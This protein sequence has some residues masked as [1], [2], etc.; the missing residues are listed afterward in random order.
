VF[1]GGLSCSRTL[2]ARH[3]RWLKLSDNCVF[4]KPGGPDSIRIF[5]NHSRAAGKPHAHSR[6]DVRIENEKILRRRFQAK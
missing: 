2:A 1:D 6:G 4:R 3:R 5:Q